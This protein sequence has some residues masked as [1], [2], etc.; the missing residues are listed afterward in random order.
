MEIGKLIVEIIC[1]SVIFSILALIVWSDIKESKRRE[2]IPDYEICKSYNAVEDKTI[3]IVQQYVGHGWYVEISSSDTL[4]E[5][6][7]IVKRI[8][9]NNNEINTSEIV[10]QYHEKHFSE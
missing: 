6:E 3:Y 9:G 7:E 10:R 4:E 5:A 2:K 1:C 8:M